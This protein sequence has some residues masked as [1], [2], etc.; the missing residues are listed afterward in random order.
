M[1]TPKMSWKQYAT[2]FVLLLCLSISIEAPPIGNIT[3]NSTFGDKIIEKNVTAEAA[4]AGLV[5]GTRRQ[6]D[7]DDYDDEDDESPE[8]AEDDDDPGDEDSDDVMRGESRGS[9]KQ[10]EKDT[11][12]KDKKTAEK[13]KKGK[14]NANK[15]KKNNKNKKKK[16]KKKKKRGKKKKKKKKKKS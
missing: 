12:E 16:K 13:D 15:D 7:D 3:V 14:Q 10:K 6:L 9:S 1:G 8:D 11:E 4:P 5:T 2:F